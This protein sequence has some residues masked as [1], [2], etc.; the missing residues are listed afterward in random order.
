MMGWGHELHAPLQLGFQRASSNLQALHHAFTDLLQHLGR[1]RGRSVPSVGGERCAAPPYET[2]KKR[3]GDSIDEAC[4]SCLASPSLTPSPP[5]PP[6]PPALHESSHGT[7]APNPLTR[8]GL[9]PADQQLTYKV[10]AR[11]NSE[12]LDAC[13]VKN[14]SKLVLA[15]DPASLERRYIERQKDAKIE[16]VNRAIALELDKFADQVGSSVSFLSPVN[17][18]L[19]LSLFLRSR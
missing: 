6:A 17:S 10:R 4:V 14:K 9:Q 5:T 11:S 18:L 1:R 16:S 12:Y 2:G 13:G 15:E 3:E 8:T 7:A 19:L